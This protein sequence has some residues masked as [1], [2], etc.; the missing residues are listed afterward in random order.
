MGSPI[1]VSLHILTSEKN[2]PNTIPE[3]RFN[4]LYSETTSLGKT[5]I[6]TTMIK[7]LKTPTL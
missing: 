2:T 3:H 7:D 1:Y 4:D 6:L 5:F